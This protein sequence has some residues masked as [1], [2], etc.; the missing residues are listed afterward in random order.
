MVMISSMIMMIMIRML[1]MMMMMMLRY[2]CNAVAAIHHSQ[3][4]SGGT[5]I[6][7][8]LSLIHI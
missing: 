6:V 1:R 8:M 4:L 3:W 5:G 7:M 2:T